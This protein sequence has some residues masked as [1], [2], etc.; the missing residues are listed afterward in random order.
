MS[1][2]VMNNVVSLDGFIADLHDDPGP[3]FDWYFNGDRPLST[4]DMDDP[5]PGGLRVSQAS[6]DGDHVV[7]VSHRPDP[8][9]GTGRGRSLS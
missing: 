8:R 1:T 7:V 2:V 4:Q 3:P 5:S 6:Y 9:G